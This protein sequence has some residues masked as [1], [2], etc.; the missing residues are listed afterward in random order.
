MLCRACPPATDDKL[1]VPKGGK[2]GNFRPKVYLNTSCG[3]MHVKLRIG[4]GGAPACQ[5]ARPPANLACLHTCTPC[6]LARPAPSR[7]PPLVI[8]CRWR[9]HRRLGPQQEIMLGRGTTP[10]P[11]DYCTCYHCLR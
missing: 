8:F 9:H 4:T 2:K 5:P 3:R 7:I 6:H 11:P 1:C 10:P